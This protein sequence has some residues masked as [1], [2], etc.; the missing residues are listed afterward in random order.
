MS[1]NGLWRSVRLATRRSGDPFGSFTARRAPKIISHT[2]GRS[3]CIRPS[4]ETLR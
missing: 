2:R 3:E 1:C 4:R